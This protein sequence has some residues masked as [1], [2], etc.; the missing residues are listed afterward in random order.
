LR[1]KLESDILDPFI[2][3][4]QPD[5]TLEFI[6]RSVGVHEIKMQAIN[7]LGAIE[8]ST[9]ITVRPAPEIDNVILR[10]VLHVQ[11]IILSRLNCF[12]HILS[13]SNDPIPRQVQIGSYE[14]KK[15]TFNFLMPQCDYLTQCDSHC[16]KP[17][18]F[19]VR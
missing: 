17:K 18:L 3:T 19:C 5:G 9:V 16:V 14:F 2:E 8:A 1:K 13:I 6:V 7:P 12:T 15:K 4:N 10:L 11:K